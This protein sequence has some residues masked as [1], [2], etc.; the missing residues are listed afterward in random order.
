MTTEARA[1]LSIT[2]SSIRDPSS[3]TRL[4]RI[5]SDLTTTVV[6]DPDVVWRLQMAVHEIAENL[7]KY[8]DGDF[9]SIEVAVEDVGES[10]IRCTVSS[11]NAASPERLAEAGRAL[12]AVANAQNPGAYYRRL[13]TEN[14]FKPGSGLGFARIRA[15]GGFALEFEIEGTQLRLKAVGQWGSGRTWVGG[16]SVPP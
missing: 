4:G 2:I 16:E 3:P 15:E 10:E 8:A 5:M 13:M 9:V 12:T 1:T 7:A 11:R 14:A 6:H